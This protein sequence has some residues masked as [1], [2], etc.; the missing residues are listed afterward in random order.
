MKKYTSIAV[1]SFTHSFGT[2]D[3][4]RQNQDPPIQID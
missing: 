1:K 2:D 3:V 4:K